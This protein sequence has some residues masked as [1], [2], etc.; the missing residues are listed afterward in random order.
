MRLKWQLIL[1]GS[2]L[3]SMV[4]LAITY[5]VSD[6][7][8]LS[9]RRQVHNHS[10]GLYRT[11]AESLTTLVIRGRPLEVERL[12]RQA[13]SAEPGIA[14]LYVTDFDGHLL[15]HTFA[16]GFPR[17]LLSTLDPT[18]SSAVYR[19]YRTAAGAIDHFSAPLIE[20]M[21]ARLYMGMDDH[22]YRTGLQALY[23]RVLL[24]AL[25]VM[26]AVLL[27]GA[28]IVR[29]ISTPL[30][31]LTGLI[32]RFGRGAAVQASQVPQQGAL[33]LRQLGRALAGMIRQRHALETSLKSSEAY[34]RMLFETSPAGLALTRMDGT[35]VEVN[36]AYAAIIG[37]SIQETLGMTYWE[38]TPGEYAAQEQAQLCSL[39]ERGSYGPYEK[40]YLHKQGH[41]VPV[42]LSGRLLERGGERYIWSVVE[43]ITEQ[44][45][46][47]WQLAE[48]EARYRQLVDN[49][50]DGM[51]LY[52]V[53]G[54]GEDFVFKDHNR[55]GERIS[56]IPRETVIGRSVR[57]V[58]P[59]IDA[60]GLFEVF[61][62]VWRSG[63]PQ[64]HPVVH[65]QDEQLAL[66]VENY[67]F[68]LPSGEIVAIYEDVTARRLADENLRYR[69]TLETALARVSSSLAQASD[70]ALDSAIDQALEY[71]G[72]T[73]GADRS[74]LFQVDGATSSFSNTHEWC[75]EG[76]SSQQPELQ[77]VPTAAFEAAFTRFRL[78]EVLH[79]PTPE[80]LDDELAP[81]RDFMH[82]TNIQSLINVPILWENRLRGVV[83]FDSERQARVWPAEDIQLLR[84][85]TE[86]FG[87]ALGRQQAS[88]HQREHAWFL[89]SLDQISAALA[90]EPHTT[91]MLRHLTQL[92]LEIYGTDRAWLLRPSGAGKPGYQ[93]P[94]ETSREEFPGAFAEGVEMPD[95]AFS[96]E[97]MRRVLVTDHPL[98]VQTKEVSDPP[99]YLLLH[100]IQSQMV[101]ALRPRIGDPWVLGVHQCSRQR[102]W[103]PTEQRLF[104]AIAERVSLALSSSQL[105]EQIR[106]S[107]RRLLAAEH[108]ARIGNWN[109]DLTSGQAIWSEEEF[110]LLGYGPGGVTPCAD[111]FMR[112]VH[113]DDRQAVQAEM[114]RVMHPEETAPYHIQHRVIG[115]DGI[116]RVVEE[117]GDVTFDTQGQ[118]LRMFGTTQD[119]TERVRLERELESHREYL[120]QLVEERTSTIRQ[121]ARI[122]D[123]THDSV[124]TTDL[125]G[126]ITS[127]NGGAERLFG[128]PADAALGRHISLVYPESRHAWL[129]QQVIPSLRAQ[130]QL[131]TEVEVRR[132]DG[133]CFP[134]H[135]SFSLLYDEQGEP[136]GMV[137]YS[138]DLSTLKQREAELDQLNRR[139]QASNKELEAFAYAVSHDL[140]APLR[141]IDGF[142]LALA[143]DYGAQLDATAHD[144]IQRVRRGAQ[145][146][147]QLID[148]MLQLSRVN[149]GELQWQEVDLSPMARQVMEELQAADP[150]RHLELMLEPG[151]RVRGDP[152]LLRVMLDN[153][154]GNA[155]KFTVKETV[156][157]IAFQRMAGERAVFRISDNGVGFDMRYRD[158]LFG[159]FQRL[160]RIS[161]FPCTGVGL[162]TVQRIVHRHGGRV[163]AEARESEGASFYFTL[164]P[165]QDQESDPTETSRG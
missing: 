33:E 114:Q 130:G 154:L 116:E 140:R 139:L 119:I 146:M 105:L 65:Y 79:A 112:V 52:Q 66:W 64:H 88:R 71:I 93:V 19:R 5:A 20:G 136:S 102:S 54:D 96:R 23:A 97:M 126:Q 110:R 10:I 95:D 165:Y 85:V 60:T 103:S 22:D 121:Q 94:I 125:K 91:P 28:V 58:F 29:R 90:G 106:Q 18:R 73:V 150:E 53:V 77:Q 147:G 160:H 75:A 72:S 149:R 87:A 129:E 107:E 113:P 42:R 99:E 152:R 45:Q 74:Y 131:E 50:S 11:L 2:G 144:Y 38:I 83:G 120:E 1:L 30:T 39:E 82:Q 111:N 148:D 156:A 81:L 159:A 35:L 108:L 122:I 48:N 61:Q 62:Q 132:A 135:L 12:L 115:A 141:A 17:A 158:K 133:S 36:P 138:I 9:Y 31:E 55:A 14:Y 109:L 67:V 3:L 137:C 57:E 8:S 123:Q 164:E 145:R 26:I 25:L 49:M 76:I 155:W 51:A 127:W 162:A 47:Q 16:A 143:E 15:A 44:V 21:T 13:R 6:L 4:T 101:M 153:L 142:S 128:L 100:R 59:G 151:L 89:E 157:R 80:A 92:I 37:R 40:E 161:E 68:K 78:G 63:E 56:G 84:T 7:Y 69:F 43:D 118:P 134:A 46:A 124:V 32:D 34:V 41:R 104:Q 86:S 24:T 27:L 70:E 117:R 98:V 163:W